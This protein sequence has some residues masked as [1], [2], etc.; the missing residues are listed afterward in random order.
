M[1]SWYLNEKVAYERRSDHILKADKYRLEK[2][3]RGSVNHGT[4]W[5]ARVMTQM[6]DMLVKW[7]HELKARHAGLAEV[8]VGASIPGGTARPC[9][10]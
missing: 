5:H 8:G 10:S 7:G 1:F 4:R 3:V 6:G 9:V 2:L